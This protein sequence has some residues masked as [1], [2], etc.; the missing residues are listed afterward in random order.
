MTL[1]MQ[2]LLVLLGL[3]TF[4]AVFVATYALAIAPVPPGTRLGVRGMKRTRA[5][6][7]SPAFGQAEPLLRWL[8]ARV[9]PLVKGDLRTKIDHQIM[10]AGDLYG[11]GPDEFVALSG[12][13][14]LAVVLLVA[15]FRATFQVGTIWM[16]LA[17]PFGSALPYF[18]LALRSERRLRRIQN[19]L[20]YSID[21]M[22]LALSA[23]L[24]FPGAIRQVVDKTSNPSDPL[25]EELNLILQEL[26]IGK[27]RRQA[28]IDFRARAPLES[29][30]EFVGAVVHAEERG[31]P[32]ADV[33]RIQAATSRQR[34]SVRAE[35]LAA[36][37]GIKILV[38]CLLVFAAV[39][40]LIV[41]PLFLKVQPLLGN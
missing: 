21:M 1:A 12:L 14:C 34:R 26:L 9:H 35:E 5:L 16:M 28:L 18:E 33:L 29:V 6:Q 23:G 8:A 41:C 7:S 39:L 40:I 38:P 25:M 19:G 3:A 4:V 10:L 27:T 31:N 13:S 36:K 24:D 2:T 30:R 11:L 37:A 22:A 17:A 20:P 15:V 32:L